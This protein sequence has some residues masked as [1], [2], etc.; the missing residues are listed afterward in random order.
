MAL[1][2]ERWQ[3]SDTIEV[4]TC[5]CS[6]ALFLDDRQEHLLMLEV[7][8]VQLTILFGEIDSNKKVTAKMTHNHFIL[9]LRNF[10]F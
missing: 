4:T 3:L 6:N 2:M 5:W 8:A 7:I 10:Q 1:L 9:T